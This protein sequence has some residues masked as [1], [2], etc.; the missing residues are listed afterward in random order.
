MKKKFSLRNEYISQFFA[1]NIKC[2]I[3]NKI[4]NRKHTVIIN[5]K[6]SALPYYDTN[7]YDASRS[8]AEEVSFWDN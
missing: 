6:V 2:E 3:I 5:K 8:T 1:I 4:V 7:L